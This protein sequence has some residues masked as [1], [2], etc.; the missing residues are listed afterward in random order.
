VLRGNLA[1]CF[2]LFSPDGKTLATGSNGGPIQL[3]NVATRQELIALE[4]SGGYTPIAFSPDGQYLASGS[5][6]DDRSVLLWRAASFAETD[7]PAVTRSH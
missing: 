5:G 7:V 3:W 4:R 2:V 6:S 1:F